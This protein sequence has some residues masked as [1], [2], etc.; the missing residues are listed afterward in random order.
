MSESSSKL[1]QLRWKITQNSR[2]VNIIA[3]M[4]CWT[5]FWTQGFSTVEQVVNVSIKI[6]RT[7]F[8]VSR[9]LNV[10]TTDRTNHLLTADLPIFKSMLTRIF[11]S[12]K[13]RKCLTPV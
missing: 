10:K 12:Q 1:S 6:S 9:L 11:L 3:R 13:S 8:N 5:L 2:K 4:I 7:E